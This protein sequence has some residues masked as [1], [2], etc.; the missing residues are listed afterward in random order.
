MPA[1][2]KMSGI[3]RYECYVNGTPNEEASSTN[4]ICKI[5]E[6]IEEN[7]MYE[8]KVVVYDNAGLSEETATLPIEMIDG[9]AS[10]T[11]GGSSRRWKQ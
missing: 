4:G 7:G 11:A 10:G 3:A 2:D 8:V 5:T 1:R 6:G 9:Y